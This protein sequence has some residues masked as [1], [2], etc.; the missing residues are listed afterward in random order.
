MV[1]MVWMV[2]SLADRTFQLWCA[3]HPAPVAEAEADVEAG[4]GADGRDEVVAA[5]R[6]QSAVEEAVGR[7]PAEPKDTSE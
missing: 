4:V 6:E 1:R 3:P 7:G 2:R 5:A